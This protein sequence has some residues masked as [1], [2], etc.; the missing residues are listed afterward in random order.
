VSARTGKP[1]ADQSLTQAFSDGLRLLG[2]PR[3]ASIHSFRAKFVNDEIEREMQHRL[4]SGLDTSTASISESVSRKLGHK[5][6]D[7]LFPYVAHAQSRIARL[8]SIEEVRRET[9]G[10][11]SK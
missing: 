2:A 10:R 9:D 3:G 11:L 8:N 5:S 6:P 1:L 4:D 7:S